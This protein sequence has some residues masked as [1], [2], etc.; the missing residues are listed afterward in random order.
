MGLRDVGVG[1]VRRFL[2]V[3]IEARIGPIR[4]RAAHRRMLLA[5]RTLPDAIE[6]IHG[7][8]GASA[9]PAATSPVFVLSAGWRSG[10]TLLQRLVMSAEEI[11]VWGE[12]YDR[13]GYIQRLAETLQALGS[14]W[15]PDRFFLTAREETGSTDHSNEWVA[16]LYPAL[17]DLRAS[18]RAFFDRLFLDPAKDRG[19]QRW[20]LK[21][22]RLS[23]EHAAY[24]KWLYPNARFLFLV[25]DPL[26]AYKSYRIFRP[27]YDRWP[28]SP[29]LTPGA[30]GRHWAGIA[31]SFL[32]GHVELD[33]RL[34]RFEDLIGGQTEIGELSTYLDLDLDPEVLGRRVT[35]RGTATL[36]DV[37][38]VEYRLLRRAVEPVA[39]SLGYDL[40]A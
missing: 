10:S 37:P 27:W 13:C 1:L 19:Y 5:I 9:A 30:F 16:N 25:R 23:A 40:S 6:E 2:K 4:H 15:P 21:E 7:R 12:P 28:E 39:S 33:A 24:L 36:A 14:E 22:V 3:P 35:G 38:A 8:H 18:H 17:A 26:A 11:L 29:V 34:I 31:E 32:Q 20:G